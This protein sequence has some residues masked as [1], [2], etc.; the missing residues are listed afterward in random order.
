M[1]WVSQAVIRPSR[2]AVI[3]F[4]G[5]SSGTRGFIDTGQ[6]LPGWD[7][8]VYISVEAVE[9]MARMIG[10]A[11]RP[12]VPPAEKEKARIA[13]LEAE[14]LQLAQVVDAVEILKNNG[15]SAKQGRTRKAAA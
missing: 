5:N 9:E 2:C 11:P 15:F 4:I 10:W 3:P 7:N 14:K 13:Q 1:R 6:D 12:T 8:H